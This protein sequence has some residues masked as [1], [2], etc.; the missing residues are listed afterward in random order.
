MKQ[1]SVK[2]LP[3]I[4]IFPVSVNLAESIKVGS[5]SQSSTM[6]FWESISRDVEKGNA[7]SP[8]D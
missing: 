6:Q 4:F 5:A 2:C 3:A 7:T 8:D 1:N